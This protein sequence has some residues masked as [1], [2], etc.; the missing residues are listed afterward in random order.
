M[1]APL[2]GRMGGLPG[3]AVGLKRTDP[4]PL[5]LHYQPYADRQQ[6]VIHRTPEPRPIAS[7]A[8]QK[9]II[10]IERQGHEPALVIS[11][12]AGHGAGAAPNF[13]ASVRR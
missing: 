11:Y 9:H 3:I 10:L 2:P 12:S 4:C 8:N 7:L 1:V 13:S 5:T 6:L